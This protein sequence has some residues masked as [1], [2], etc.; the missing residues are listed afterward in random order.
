[1]AFDKDAYRDSYLRPKS[2]LKLAALQDDLFERYAIKLPMSDADI[3][4]TVKEVRSF[5]S[6]QQAGTPAAKYAKLCLAADEDLKQQ[7]VSSGPNRGKDMTSATWWQEKQN[8]LTSAAEVRV[9]KLASLL[10][11]SN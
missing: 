10:K 6:S 11:D 7:K 1:M 2:R 9:T 5:W 4:A 3:V 8:E